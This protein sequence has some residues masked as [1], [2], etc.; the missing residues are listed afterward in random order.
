[1]V[2]GIMTVEIF[3][4][5]A[6]SLK[7]KRQVVKSVIER[8][9]TRFNVSVAEVGKQNDLQWA[10]IGMA[11]VSNST[12]HVESQMDHILNFMNGDGRFSVEEIEREVQHF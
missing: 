6:F 8:L 5:D 4:G 12:E 11:C 10:V 3:L 7:E 2:V 1:M 9:K